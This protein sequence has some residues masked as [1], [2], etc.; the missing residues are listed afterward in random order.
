VFAKL[1]V[2]AVCTPGAEAIT[3]Y[4]PTFAFALNT[5]EVANPLASVVAVLVLEPVSANVPLAPVVGAVKVTTTPLTED[6]FL[7]TAATRGN[8]KAPPIAWLCGVPLIAAIASGADPARPER[9]PVVQ[10]TSPIRQIAT[11]TVQQTLWFIDSY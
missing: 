4:A 1:K 10:P 7:V 6:P 8:A 11:S 3:V 5:A 9:S 2:A